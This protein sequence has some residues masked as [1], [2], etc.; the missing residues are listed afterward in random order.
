MKMTEETEERMKKKKG[1]ITK[2]GER[3]E[4]CGSEEVTQ[5]PDHVIAER[6]CQNAAEEKSMHIRQ[7]REGQGRGRRTKKD[8]R[9]RETREVSLEASGSCRRSRPSREDPRCGRKTSTIPEAAAGGKAVHIC[10]RLPHKHN[11]AHI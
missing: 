3:R 7:R 9:R 10:I 2:D 5:L 6:R 1:M 11:H 4:D 8:K